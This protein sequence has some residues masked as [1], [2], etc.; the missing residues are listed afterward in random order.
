MRK[1][2]FYLLVLSILPFIGLGQLL[3]E[4]FEGSTFPP[5][6]WAITQTNLSETW[7]S[8][9]WDTGLA[10]SV[11]YDFDLEDQDEWLISPSISLAGAT[12]PYLSF[13]IGYSYYWAVAP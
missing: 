12:D 1:N 5:S 11:D 3:Q 7:V 8:S 6:G 10:A 2:L 9:T 4:D 13:S